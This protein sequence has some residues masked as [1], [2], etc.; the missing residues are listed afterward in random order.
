MCSLRSF[1]YLS[2]QFLDAKDVMIPALLPD[3]GIQAI[4]QKHISSLPSKIVCSQLS[5]L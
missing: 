3:Q 2:L 4:D 1:Q 5:F